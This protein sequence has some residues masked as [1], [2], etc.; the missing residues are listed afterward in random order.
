MKRERSEDATLNDNARLSPF[1]TA[2]YSRKSALIAKR[3]LNDFEAV[4]IIL[5]YLTTK[6]IAFPLKEGN[7]GIKAVKVSLN[8]MA[9]VRIAKEL[10]SGST[11]Y[12]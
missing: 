9:K 8:Q 11:S 5:K 4:G 1:L 12:S 2:L 7:D 10:Y 3:S 6:Y